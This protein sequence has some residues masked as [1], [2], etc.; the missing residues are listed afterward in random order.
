[1]SN[2][3]TIL[4][5]V[6]VV[7]FVA[8]CN[9]TV[10]QQPLNRPKGSRPAAKLAPP[11][12]WERAVL[13]T[14]FTDARE[15]LGTG[16]APGEATPQAADDATPSAPS[17]KVPS[18]VPSGSR[19]SPLVSSTTLENEVK[20]QVQP[21]AT[22]VQTPTGFK[23]GAYKAAREEL[24]LLGVLFGVIGQY[25]G[26]VRWQKDANSLRDLFGRAGS[27]CKVGTDNSFNEAKLRSQDLSEL[28]RGGT[29]EA[30]DAK[31]DFQWPEVANRPPLM[32]RMERS[33]RERLGPWTGSKGEFTKHRDAILHEAEL[34]AVLARVIK[35]E[36]YEYADDATY[37][38]YVDQLERQCQ[39][40]IEATKNGELPK[41]Q[42]AASQM[43]KTCDA[44]HGDFR[45]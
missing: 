20:A 25:D 30:R 15:R 42:S 29:L 32:K 36:G 38:E 35:T 28:V 23:G 40:I 24:T 8:P 45:S 2:P 6:L 5:T 1:M 43:N 39:E 44:C 13:E 21:L 12:K 16:P 18:T 26:E 14:F 4:L 10:A 9:M 33:L 17:L 19:W 7:T 27:N 3:T 41:A 31:E 34:L 22:A 37:R 11:P